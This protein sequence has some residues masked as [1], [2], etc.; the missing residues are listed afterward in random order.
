[1]GMTKR[2][3]VLALMIVVGAATYAV[4]QQPQPSE[5]VK[6]IQS[7]AG[8][9]TGWATPPSGSAF[10]IEVFINPDGTYSSMMAARTGTGTFKVD[11][12]KITT[13]GHISGP[14]VGDTWSQVTH[15]TQGGRQVLTGAGRSEAGPFNYE[16][17]KQ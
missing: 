10:P 2:I 16:L 15:S 8:R 4:A 12:G 13:T 9:W 6:D 1:M 14:T 11:Q 5:A 7:L 17:T 3:L